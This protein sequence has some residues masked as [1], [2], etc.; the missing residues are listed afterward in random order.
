MTLSFTEYDLANGL[1]VIL[2]PDSTA[3]VVTVGMMYH[4]GAK[5]EQPERTGFAHFFEHL[6]FEGTKIISRGKWFDI[7]SANGGH[8]NAFTTQDK[9]YFY[10][11]FP[12]NNL[13]LA[14]WMEAERLLHPIINEI[15]VSTQNSV[16]KEEKSQ[17]ID[18]AP[19]GR[20]MYREAINR[21]LFGQH[22]YKGT[23]IGETAH[24]DA[25]TLDEFVLFKK[26]FYNPNNAVL[27]VAGD[28]QEATAKEWIA[29][30]F[31]NNHNTADK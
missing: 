8:N 7:V 20:I 26:R 4:V 21:Y 15:G 19:Y 13:E 22:P 10:E 5:D 29:K 16:V 30:Y 11:V 27:V 6:L 1:H 12:A 31:A 24:L 2:Y 25:A 14:L 17:R 23:V 28:F 3:P 9:T 18:N